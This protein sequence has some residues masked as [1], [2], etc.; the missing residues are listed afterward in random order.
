[1]AKVSLQELAQRATSP[2]AY[3]TPDIG[4]GLSDLATAVLDD[5]YLETNQGFKARTD[6]ESGLVRALA[7]NGISNAPIVTSLSYVEPRTRFTA[8]DGPQTF[9]EITIST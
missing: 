3:T 6:A 4:V 1:M 7:F 8:H 9:A 5:P 2:D